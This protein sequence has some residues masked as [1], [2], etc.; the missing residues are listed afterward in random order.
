MAKP[1]TKKKYESVAKAE[2][3][4]EQQTAAPAARKRQ[5]PAAPRGWGAEARYRVPAVVLAVA[6]FANTLSGAFVYDDKRQIVRNTL[7]QDGTQFWRALLSDVW[8]FKAGAG[9]ASNYWRPSFVLWMIVNFRLFGLDDTT[10]WHVANVALHAAVVALA[11]LLLRRLD[12][13]K[14]IAAAVAL[15]FA[16]HPAHTESVAWISGS[17]DLVMGAALLGSLL[18]VARLAERETPAR[19]AAALGL[20]AIALG[21]KEVAIFYPAIVVAMLWV[22]SWRAGE[23]GRSLGQ[24]IRVAAP[25]AALATIYFVARLAILGR[26]SQPHAEGAGLEGTLLTAPA[27]FVFYLRQVVFPV[28]IG[29]SYPLRAVTF[30]TIGLGNFVVPLLVS[31]AA[32]A[33]MAWLARRSKVARFGL[34]LFLLPLVPAMNVGAFHPEQLVHDRYLYLPLLGFLVLALPPLAEAVERAAR[35]APERARLVVLVAAAVACVPLFVQTVRYNRAWLDEVALWG[36]GTRSDPTSAFNYLEYGVALDNAGRLDEAAAAFDRSLEIDPIANAYVGRARVAIKQERFAD[37]ERDLQATLAAQAA[38]P[39]DAYVLYQS[40]E[41]LAVAYEH[42]GQFDKASALLVDAR[43]RLPIYTAAITVKLA[44][45]LYEAG[46]KPEALA[47]LERARA[48]ARTETLPESKDVLFR[49]GQL[50]AEAGRA[51]DARAAFQ[52][53]LNTTAALRAPSVQQTRAQAQAAVQ[54]LQGR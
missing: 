34:A 22:G 8:A 28:W 23:T 35:L 52:E 47:E 44:V 41:A 21:A 39:E 5:P 9:V 12:V 40:Y 33:G 25:F 26:V 2:P 43:T 1:H 29:P 49:L 30:A 16:V 11:Y 15:V 48:A 54:K 53:Y 37:A 20:Y 24:S 19:W 27:A 36:W 17:P 51:S 45:V 42:Q 4:A 10:G 31:V 46:R 7:I 50:Y 6:A 14:E 13:A 38:D 18:V 32:L 3:P